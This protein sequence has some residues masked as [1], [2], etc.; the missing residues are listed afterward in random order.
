M[1]D[2]LDGNLAALQD[3]ANQLID[4][5]KT[6]IQ[7]LAAVLAMPKAK[8]SPKTSLP[9]TSLIKQLSAKPAT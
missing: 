5:Q 2:A 4:A 3:K 8:I 1:D 7:S 6:Q 9:A